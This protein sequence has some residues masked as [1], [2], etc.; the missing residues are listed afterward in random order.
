MPLAAVANMPK[1]TEVGFKQSLGS[2]LAEIK[3]SCIHGL[4][5][6]FVIRYNNFCGTWLLP[7]VKYIFQNMIFLNMISKKTEPGQ[8]YMM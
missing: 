5:T 7:A 4:Y 8:Q 1:P 2:L 6:F 3:I